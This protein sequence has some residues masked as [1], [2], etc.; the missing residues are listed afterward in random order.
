MKS[1]VSWIILSCS[2]ESDWPFAGPYYLHLQGR[3]VSQVGSQQKAA[4]NDKSLP[5]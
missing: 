1:A 5:K 2:S 4:V 3:R